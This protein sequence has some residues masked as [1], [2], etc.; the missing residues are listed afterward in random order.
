MATGFL[1][2]RSG[3]MPQKTTKVPAPKPGV[4]VPR[5]VSAA[6]KILTARATG[7]PVARL[8]NVPGIPITT[9]VRAAPRLT[10]PVAPGAMPRKQFVAPKVAVPMR[11]RAPGANAVNPTVFDR[12]TRGRILQ[13][14]T[15]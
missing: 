11:P 4:P 5:M 14:G 12:L 13:R 2:K 1:P 9:P 3:S 10:R 8:R 6:A 7:T 15:R